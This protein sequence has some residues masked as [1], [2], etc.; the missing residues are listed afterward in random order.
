MIDVIFPALNEALA[1]P[2]VIDRLPPDYRAIVVDNG[3]TDDTAAVAESLGAVVVPE[4]RLGYGA[5][6]H[7]GVLRADGEIIAITDADGSWD[8]RE[9]TGLVSLITDGDAELAVD[10]RRPTCRRAWPWYARLGNR[11]LG[12]RVSRSL[13]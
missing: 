12:L 9:L 11:L 6:V 3:S 4:T 1:L 7:A 10:R 2:D 13:G 5:A 8:A